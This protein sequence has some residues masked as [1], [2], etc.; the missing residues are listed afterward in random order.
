MQ[1]SGTGRSR[2]LRYGW[3]GVT[4]TLLGKAGRRLWRWRQVALES[5]YDRAGTKQVLHGSERRRGWR[6]QTG[7]SE[8]GPIGRNMGAAVVRKKQ[9]QIEPAALVE[10]SEHR[11]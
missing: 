7:G 10:A 2:K 9:D 1:V 11:K 8:I 3:S 4:G 6:R 5:I